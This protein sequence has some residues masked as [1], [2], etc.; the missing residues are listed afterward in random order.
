[1]VEYRYCQWYD[2]EI[3]IEIFQTHTCQ[4]LL[5]GRISLAVEK[6][7]ADVDDDRPHYD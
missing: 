2:R 6:G 7:D 1:M 3:A 4:R 5:L